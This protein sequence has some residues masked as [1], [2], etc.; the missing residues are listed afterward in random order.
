MGENGDIAR[1]VMVILPAVLVHLLLQVFKL[2]NNG[3]FRLPITNIVDATDPVLFI[4]ACS[5]PGPW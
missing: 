2:A 4:R 5:S 3:V 1:G